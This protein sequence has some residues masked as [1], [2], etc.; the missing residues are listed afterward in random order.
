[1]NNYR[2]LNIVIMVVAGL[3][4]IRLVGFML[5]FG[6]GCLQ[7]DFCAFYTAGEASRAGLSPYINHFSHTPPV[8]D[9]VGVF[10]HSRFLYPPLVAVLFHP[11]ALLPYHV[12]KYFWML[13]NLLA[14]FASLCVAIRVSAPT[15]RNHYSWGMILFLLMFSPLLILLERGQIDGISL[16]LVTTSIALIATGKRPGVS[17][18]LIALAT[19]LKLHTILLLPFLVLRGKWRVIA[20]FV[21]G[22]LFILMLSVMLCGRSALVRY[23]KVEFPRISAFGEGGTRDMRADNSV[24][25]SLRPVSSLVTKE[26]RTYQLEHFK[27]VIN[28]SVARTRIGQWTRDSLSKLGLPSSMSIVSLLIFGGFFSLAVLFQWRMRFSV[29]LKPE[30][31]FLYWQL[32]LVIVLL[33]APLTWVMNT[34]WLVALIPFVVNKLMERE[35]TGRT[36]AWG[37]TLITLGLLVAAAPDYLAFPQQLPPSRMSQLAGDCKYV[38]AELAILAGLAIHLWSSG[39]PRLKEQESQAID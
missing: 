20:G 1:M 37:I 7:M 30:T 38:I 21:I 5:S 27:F 4:F 25:S 22:T 33:S 3:A 19:L 32:A 28:A 31:E 18:V 26:G 15:L 10:Q 17:G 13:A 35:A 12:A 11:L 6:E 24:I 8:W 34:I 14:V 9:G 2:P 36:S 39:V 16:V 23:A 29:C